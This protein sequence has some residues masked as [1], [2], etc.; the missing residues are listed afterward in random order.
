MDAHGEP[1]EAGHDEEG[2]VKQSSVGRGK[3]QNGGARPDLPR[4]ERII[5]GQGREA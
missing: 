2:E 1:F 4:K 5:R 3:V